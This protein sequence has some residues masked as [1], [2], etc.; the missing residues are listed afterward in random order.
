MLFS[1]PENKIPRT[2]KNIGCLS[3]CC[4]KIN[5]RNKTFLPK[6]FINQCA[7]PMYIFVPNLHKERTGFGQ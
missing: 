6:Y 3:C 4:L 7:Y 2:R 1:I 5:S